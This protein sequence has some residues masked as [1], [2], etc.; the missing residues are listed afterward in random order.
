MDELLF[1]DGAYDRLTPLDKA[2]F[3]DFVVRGRAPNDTDLG[4]KVIPAGWVVER[5]IGWLTRYRRHGL[6][7]F[8]KIPSVPRD[9]RHQGDNG[10][11][12]DFPNCALVQQAKLLN[13]V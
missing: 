1:A 5:S 7:G 8:P 4:F 3:L 12:A 11:I 2:A 13:L 6:R 9:E 10:G